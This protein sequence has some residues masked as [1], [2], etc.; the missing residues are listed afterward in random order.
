MPALL[1]LKNGD[2]RD[3]SLGRKVR[4]GVLSQNVGTT[5]Y[6]WELSRSFMKTEDIKVIWFFF[7]NFQSNF[8]FIIPSAKQILQVA[9]YSVLLGTFAVTLSIVIVPFL[10]ALVSSLEANIQVFFSIICPAVL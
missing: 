6:G 7:A 8:A 9:F 2:K 1:D 5:G 4:K 10:H 3:L